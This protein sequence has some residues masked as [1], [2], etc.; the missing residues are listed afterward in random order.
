MFVQS[1]FQ[2]ARH[3][4]HH[5]YHHNH[6]HQQQQPQQHQQQQQYDSATAA[7]A[8]GAQSTATNGQSIV[9]SSSSSFGQT[10]ADHHHHQPDRSDGD[11]H[12]KRGPGQRLEL[13][14][15]ETTNCGAQVIR[16]HRKQRQQKLE[17]SPTNNKQRP[18]A[19]ATAD[20]S[21]SNRVLLLASKQKQ[22]QLAA[23]DGDQQ[24]PR[25]KTVAHPPQSQQQAA[26]SGRHSNDAPTNQQMGFRSARFT[27]ATASS[28]PSQECSLTFSETIRRRWASKLGAC[29]TIRLRS[30]SLS[31]GLAPRSPTTQD[32]PQHRGLA[33]AAADSTG[34]K[35]EDQARPQLRSTVQRRAQPSDVRKGHADQAKQT[36]PSSASR[37]GQDCRH[38]ANSNESTTIGETSARLFQTE[39]GSH[40]T[41][42]A[43]AAIKRQQYQ[44]TS[45]STVHYSKR[46]GSIRKYQVRTVSTRRISLSCSHLRLLC[47]LIEHQNSSGLTG[48]VV[49]ELG[50]RTSQ[51]FIAAATAAIG[52]DNSA[53]TG[54]TETQNHPID[55][56]RLAWRLH[57]NCLAA[58]K[59]LGQTLQLIRLFLAHL[60]AF[61]W[62]T[63]RQLVG[64]GAAKC[65]EPA[66]VEDDSADMRRSAGDEGRHQAC[67]PLEQFSQPVP[68]EPLDDVM[69]DHHH[70]LVQQHHSH[71]P[72]SPSNYNQN[73]DQ[74]CLHHQHQQ[75]AS[76]AGGSVDPHRH[77]H[78]AARQR[79]MSSGVGRHVSGQLYDPPSHHHHHHHHEFSHHHATIDCGHIAHHIMA[80]AHTK[81]AYGG[82]EQQVTAVTAAHGATLMMTPHTYPA[83]QQLAQ[84]MA[85]DYIPP[86]TGRGRSA[87][88]PAG[89]IHNDSSGWMWR[90]RHTVDG[91]PISLARHRRIFEANNNLAGAPHAGQMSSG[92]GRLNPSANPLMAGQQRT[93]I[94]SPTLLEG[95]R[96]LQHIGGHWPQMH[97]FDLNSGRDKQH[98]GQRAPPSAPVVARSTGANFIGAIQANHY[99]QQQQQQ[100][101]HRSHYHSVDEPPNLIQYHTGGSRS[102]VDLRAYHHG[103]VHQ[104][105]HQSS[106]GAG[107][108]HSTRPGTNQSERRLMLV[109]GS[110]SELAKRAAMAATYYSSSSSLSSAP[111]LF[112]PDQSR[113][114]NLARGDSQQ[115]LAAA[116]S[117]MALNRRRLNRQASSTT[118]DSSFNH[119]GIPSD[120]GSEQLP[121]HALLKSN[122]HTTGLAGSQLASTSNCVAQRLGTT[123]YMP[124]LNA[125]H[126]QQMV[127][128]AN[129]D[130]HHQH[131][132]QHQ[133]HHNHHH[134]QHQ[135]PPPPASVAVDARSQRAD[136]SA[137]KS[138]TQQ[139][140]PDRKGAPQQSPASAG[141]GDGG[142]PKKNGKLSANCKSKSVSNQHSPIG[143]AAS[144]GKVSLA[145]AKRRLGFKQNRGL[146]SL[147]VHRSEEIF[148]SEASGMLA[149]QYTSTTTTTTTTGS[150]SL[151]DS[152]DIELTS[153]WLNQFG[154]ESP[155]PKVCFVE[156]LGLGQIASRQALVSP[157]L[158]DIQVSLSDRRGMLEVEIIR[159]RQLQPKPYA[160]RLPC[161]CSY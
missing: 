97:L 101:Q 108:A 147:S 11:K 38:Q 88:A 105:S 136:N 7:G 70:H 37:S 127:S 153:R 21:S 1:H 25:A 74:Y 26:L 128:G 54:A 56:D 4:N 23:G 103:P 113:K 131:Q 60:L 55:N 123:N 17:P 27:Q 161:K 8:S 149:R 50:S 22:I 81:L 39:A 125:T 99:Q 24:H 73:I 154:F 158:G 12:V 121:R 85:L 61:Q 16:V 44:A 110:D 53:A 111:N 42:T 156:G 144:L 106:M 30:A 35:Q 75:A 13:A 14:L 143:V 77:D 66:P 62:E 118:S 71:H 139:T 78:S 151:N 79:P 58:L 95:E 159:V 32:G 36:A 109:K 140:A 6:H 28:P 120:A 107:G 133:H 96:R 102:P 83:A 52:A 94:S 59:S 138:L 150:N 145:G 86:P 20:S 76:L 29:T 63:T 9:S 129:L 87:G 126:Y 124:Q 5:H 112:R 100:Q 89:D 92:A 116:A 82:G 47:N 98:V 114:K 137:N 155:D 15:F 64:L 130:T 90:M 152:C 31:A 34:P 157:Y 72:E 2:R 119:Y 160:K 43:T 93:S 51:P 141:A 68:S 18:S 41:T 48:S 10:H 19:P 115:Q 84:T 80:P 46:R 67:C 134:H 146:N 57:L 148:P 3:H 45:Q 49:G 69:S 65:T 104:C 142:G 117:K 135:Q 33:A 132:H 40:Q 122:C 91:S